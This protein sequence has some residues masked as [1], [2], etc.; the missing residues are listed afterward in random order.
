MEPEERHIECTGCGASLKYAPDQQNLICDFCGL[1]I[2][3]PRPD[4]RV[5]DEHSCDCFVP[6]IVGKDKPTDVTRAY[7]ISGAYTPDDILDNSTITKQWIFYVPTYLFRVSYK[8]PWTASFGY[9]HTE[10][11]TV[12][13]RDR[14]GVSRPIT[15]YKTVTDWKPHSGVDTGTLAVQVYGGNKLT[16]KVV[17]LVEKGSIEN[18]TTFDEKFTVGYDI[19]PFM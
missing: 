2:S 7:M 11:Y 8:A 3:I 9:D 17:D 5:P 13:Q 16:Q 6:L 4:E 12:F 18:V 14:S 1:Q 15:K 19:E 10:P